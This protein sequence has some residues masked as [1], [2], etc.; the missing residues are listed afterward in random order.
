MKDATRTLVIWQDSTLIASFEPDGSTPPGPTPEPAKYSFQYSYT[1]LGKVT[2]SVAEG[3]YDEG[4]AITLEATPEK[5]WTFAGWS[6]G[7][8]K[9]KLTIVLSQ[10]T[11]LVASFVTTKKYKVTIKAGSNGKVD[12]ALNEA[13]YTGGSV[14]DIKAI[15]NDEYKFIKWSDGN[16]DAERSIVI[17]QDTSLTASFEE[18]VYYTLTVEIEPNENAGTVLFDGKENSSMRK[19]VE[20][21]KTI[22]LSAE[23]S[24]GY[25]FSHYEDG[26]SEITNA[27]YSVVMNKKR[28]VTAVFKKAQGLDDVTGSSATVSQKML[29][30]GTIYILRGDK[31]YTLDGQAVK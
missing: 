11:N 5:D 2:S 1:G 30:N 24:K 20:E 4:T 26:A 16:T 28:T 23:P 31:I 21:G 17:T 15:P 22:V 29:I 3:T 7:S 6:N 10:D 13:E 18:I 14:I 25:A 9:A 27:E 12:P 8:K 19:R